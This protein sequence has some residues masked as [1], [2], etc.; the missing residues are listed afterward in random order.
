M[1]IQITVTVAA[2]NTTWFGEQV[3]SQCR[4]PA[5]PVHM[6]LH[7]HEWNLSWLVYRSI[8]V[9]IQLPSWPG[10]NIQTT[11]E[12]TPQGAREATADARLSNVLFEWFAT[13]LALE[14]CTSEVEYRVWSCRGTSVEFRAC[15][16]LPLGCTVC[17]LLYKTEKLSDCPS[18]IFAL[19]SKL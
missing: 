11:I 19:C 3:Q 6:Q 5:V 15:A 4:H 17:Y 14:L 7:W 10:S 16:M 13:R 1:V 9:T 2:R 12:F 8:G 18:A